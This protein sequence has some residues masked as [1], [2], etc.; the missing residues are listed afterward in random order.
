LDPEERISLL[1]RHSQLLKKRQ[2]RVRKCGAEGGRQLQAAYRQAVV[3]LNPCRRKRE[4]F[5]GDE[6]SR[7]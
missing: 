6:A 4:E 1:F 2:H 5:Q 3:Q 7:G